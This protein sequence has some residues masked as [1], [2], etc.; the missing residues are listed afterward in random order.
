MVSAALI[1]KLDQLPPDLQ[2]QIEKDV[3]RLLK[4][5]TNADL[6]NSDQT[7]RGYG[8]LKGKIWVSE[9][10]DEPLEDFKDY[11]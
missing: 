11:M 9:D 7:I 2:T 5:I 6:V 10:F 1:K 8:S 3:D 4:K